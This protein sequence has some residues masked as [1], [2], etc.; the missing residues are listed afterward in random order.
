MDDETVTQIWLSVNKIK[1]KDGE[2]SEPAKTDV[3]LVNDEE[4][5]KLLFALFKTLKNEFIEGEELTK[6]SVLGYLKNNFRPIFKEKGDLTE[7]ITKKIKK[8]ERYKFHKGSIEITGEEI[9]ER[10]KSL[11]R[12]RI[13]RWKAI[14]ENYNEN[15]D[16]FNTELEEYFKPPKFQ[17]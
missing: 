15:K 10:M 17:E 5:I 2:D 12:K 16:R 1:V 11:R 8:L 3:I 14:L 6:D 7:A 4:G 13:K 9:I